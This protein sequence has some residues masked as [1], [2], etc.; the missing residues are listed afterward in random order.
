MPGAIIVVE[1]LPDCPW[2]LAGHRIVTMDEYA[3]TPRLAPPGTG[4]V[5]LCRTRGDPARSYECSML[6]EDRR[7]DVLPRVATLT[8]LTCR[9][10]QEAMFDRL[11]REL[12][13][14][15]GEHPSGLDHGRSIPI[16]FGRT[17]DPRLLPLAVLAFEFFP[18]PM[19]AIDIDERS[20]RVTGVRAV[21]GRETAAMAGDLFRDSLDAW[22]S[23]RQ[24]I[25]PAEGASLHR[26]WPREFP[27]QAH[28][29]S[30]WM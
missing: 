2:P 24:P 8:G 3:R 10:L 13:T 16:A 30:H 26:P 21:T 9:S 11:G 6:A 29:L 12:A 25:L 4:I 7:H 1:R 27:R 23:T 19:L 14:R 5:N 28:G 22:L 15:V 17:G 18:C 20:R